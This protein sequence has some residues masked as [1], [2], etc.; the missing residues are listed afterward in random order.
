MLFIVD[1]IGYSP[2]FPIWYHSLVCIKNYLFVVGIGPICDKDLVCIFWSIYFFVR[3]IEDR[4]KYYN[5][6]I[7]KIFFSNFVWMLFVYDACYVLVQTKK[8]FMFC[9]YISFFVY[10]NTQHLLMQS[11]FSCL[12]YL[13]ITGQRSNNGVRRL[14][15]ERS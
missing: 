6:N 13:P 10:Q 15:W 1:M 11:K 3:L 2:R 7:R 8:L 14:Y 9:W 5:I 12:F 4:Y